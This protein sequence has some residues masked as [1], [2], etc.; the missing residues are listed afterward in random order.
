MKTLSFLRIFPFFLI[1]WTSFSSE[2]TFELK[3][4]NLKR[5]K[6]YRSFSQPRYKLDLSFQVQEKVIEIPFENGTQLKGRLENIPVI[7]LDTTR[8][9]EQKKQVAES[10]IQA[11]QQKEL[12]LL[13]IQLNEKQLKVSQ[14]EYERNKKLFQQKQISASQFDVIELNY[15]QAKLSFQKSK[16]EHQRAISNV[17]SLS[18]QLKLS[19]DILKKHTLEAPRGY[20]IE[21]RNIEV[22]EVVTPLQP[23]ITLINTD[24]IILPFY[25]SEKELSSLLKLNQITLTHLQSNT[26]V[27]ATILNVENIHAPITKK[28]KVVFI[29]NNNQ[30]NFTPGLEFSLTLS[31]ETEKQLYKAPADYVGQGYEHYYIINEKGIKI[32]IDVMKK[33]EEW[34]YF[35]SSQHLPKFIKKIN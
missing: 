6:E 30:K 35:R 12:S 4:E 19:Q 17:N 9:Q 11:H 34:L 2:K 29:I 14:K 27:K 13:Q 5:N 26:L 21:S 28:R 15:E 25:F 7:Y 23:I 24:S 3:K 16:L 33:D 31:L 18:S 20:R 10:L 8:A 1:L 22:G 32:S